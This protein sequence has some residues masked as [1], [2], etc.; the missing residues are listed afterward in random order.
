MATDQN[1]STAPD[2]PNPSTIITAILAAIVAEIND[3]RTLVGERDGLRTAHVLVR[4]VADAMG[5]KYD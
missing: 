3:N 4:Q 2:P 5:V 1:Q